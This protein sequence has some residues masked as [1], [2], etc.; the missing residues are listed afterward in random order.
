MKKKI[1][2]ILIIATGLINMTSCKANLSSKQNN[3]SRTIVIDE[4]TKKTS[5]TNSSLK[6]TRVALSE[7]I[8]DRVTSNEKTDGFKKVLIK[9]KL[10]YFKSSNK[11][12]RVS[13]FQP[14]YIDKAEFGDITEKKDKGGKYNIIKWEELNNIKGQ[15]L[16]EYMEEHGAIRILD[17]NKVYTIDQNGALREIESYRKLINEGIEIG[18]GI[19]TGKNGELDI[20]RGQDSKEGKL[21]SLK[22]IDTEK[23]KFYE[24]KGKDIESLNEVRIDVIDIDKEKIYVKISNLNDDGYKFGYFEGDTFKELISSKDNIK[25]KTSNNI[26]YLNNHILFF[27]EVDGK[28]GLYNLDLTSKNI[29]KIMEIQDQIGELKPTLNYDKVAI[30]TFKKKDNGEYIRVNLYIAKMDKNLYLSNITVV[31]S[32][33]TVT[34]DYFAGWISSGDGFYIATFVEEDETESYHYAK[35]KIE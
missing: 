32:A 3:N 30:T 22:I 8:N 13:Q 9:D 18:V 34:K 5:E 26:L 31:N 14:F 24:V 10:L 23:D 7:N 28:E 2:L 15:L 12:D 17:T 29:T 4:D 19:E 16:S 25:I 21:K 20:Y 35:Y 6:I 11:D 1:L 27:G 33:I